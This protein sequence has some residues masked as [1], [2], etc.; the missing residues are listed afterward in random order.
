[1]EDFQTC[2]CFPQLPNYQDFQSLSIQIQRI[3][4]NLKPPITV[5]HKLHFDPCWTDVHK[6]SSLKFKNIH[7]NE[8]L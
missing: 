3:L 5:H 4:L 8:F 2:D 7:W 1:M 6:T